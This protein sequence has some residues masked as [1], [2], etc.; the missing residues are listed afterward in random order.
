MPTSTVKWFNAE[1]GFGFIL[2]ASSGPDLF[3]HYTAIIGP[4]YRSLHEDQKV[5]FDVVQGHKGPH[6]E[7]ATPT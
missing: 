7:K 4:G 1:K 2:Q 5:S 3:A 6:A